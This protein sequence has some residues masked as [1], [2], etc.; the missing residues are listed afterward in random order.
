VGGE[1]GS[2]ARLRELRGRRVL[3]HVNNTNPLLLED[4]AER[5]ALQ[6]AGVELAFDGM[7]IEL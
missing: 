1:D 5:A 7:E 4:S 6:E 3:I 2:L